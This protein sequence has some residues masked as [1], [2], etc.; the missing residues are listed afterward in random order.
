MKTYKKL[1]KE[2]MDEWTESVKLNKEL[3]EDNK[4]L[5]DI[6][7]TLINICEERGNTITE[8]LNMLKEQL[9]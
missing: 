9:C 2:V 4:K 3:F 6:N 8:L 5:G 7:F 1:H